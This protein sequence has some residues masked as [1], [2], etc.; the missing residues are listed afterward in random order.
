MGSDCLMGTGFPSGM[1]KSLWNEV[2][3]I[4]V[5]LC[6]RAQ[7]HTELQTVSEL[8]VCQLHLDWTYT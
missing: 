2:M 4:A 1:V 7:S 6:E 5:H 8:T 3:V